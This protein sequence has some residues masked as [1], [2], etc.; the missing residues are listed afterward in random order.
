M[1][2]GLAAALAGLSL[3]APA[4]ASGFYLQEQS[5]RGDG[6]AF[7]GEVADV[8]PESL[9]WNPA[10]IAS[11]PEAAFGAISG[12]FPSADVDDR[13]STLTLPVPPAGLTVPV[14]GRPHAGD[15]IENGPVVAAGWARPVGE[16][17][18][19]GLSLATPFGE[20]IQYQPDSF[21]RYGA[22]TS[23]LLTADLQ[24][25][26]AYQAA[27]WVD[28]GLGL[29]AVYTSAR[30]TNALPNLAPGAPDGFSD[31]HGSGWDWGWNVGARVH[32][33]LDDRWSVGLSYRSAVRREFPIDVT[34]GG[35]L[36]PLAAANAN[37][38][39]SA[40]IT[41]PWFA[42]IGGRYR[43]T[44]ALTLDGQ[45]QRVGWSEFRDIRI[46]FP[47]VSQAIPQD[48]H[49]ITSAAF[50]LDYAVNPRAVVRAGVQWD[51]TPTPDIGRSLRLPDGDRWLFGIGGELGMGANFTLEGALEYADFLGSQVNNRPVFFEGT[52]AQTV[53]HYVADSNGR[54]TVVSIGA[55]W[56][57]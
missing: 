33:P 4:H 55:R 25:T 12:I 20:A 32:P 28:V 45:I 15:P 21:A 29:D 37:T 47:G 36:G 54:A 1:S 14:G 7:S 43:V 9:W 53:A 44:S 23:N 10:A 22:L 24:L 18:A 6:R 13:G 2:T 48:F 19:L 40:R 38:Q 11:S 8:G 51:P 34:I 31:L 50:G 26:G 56:R 30:L 52:P 17:F 39:G 57:F 27:P 46:E 42:S 41:T 5:V 35:L 16:R 49:D 3:C